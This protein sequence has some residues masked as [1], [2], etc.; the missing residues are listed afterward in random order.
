MNELQTETL[1]SESTPTEDD[2]NMS[3]LDQ[4]REIEKDMFRVMNTQVRLAMMQV[5]LAALGIAIALILAAL[6]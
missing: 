2:T 1:D 6:H 4:A 3:L 5:A